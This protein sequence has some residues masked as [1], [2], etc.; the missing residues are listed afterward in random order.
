MHRLVGKYLE[1]YFGQTQGSNIFRHLS[2]TAIHPTRRFRSFD[3]GGTRYEAGAD[4]LCVRAGRL[5]LQL[6]SICP[7][8]VDITTR[9]RVLND[10]AVRAF[11][12]GESPARP[13]RR[14]KRVGT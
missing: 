9:D 2:A 13:R 14:P 3:E 4:V 5:F 7:K 11:E 6:A 12:P 8:G 10:A 1:M